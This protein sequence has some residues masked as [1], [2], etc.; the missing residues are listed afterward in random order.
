MHFDFI[1]NDFAALFFCMA[2]LVIGPFKYTP[3]WSDYTPKWSDVTLFRGKFLS[4][5]REALNRD[6]L[7]QKK[8]ALCLSSP[9]ESRNFFTTCSIPTQK[10]LRSRLGISLV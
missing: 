5:F 1:G 2:F 7:C 9:G 3:K 10:L 6:K 8:F 4:R